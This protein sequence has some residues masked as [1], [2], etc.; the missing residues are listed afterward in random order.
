MTD[1]IAE[2]E[3]SLRRRRRSDETIRQY[4]NALRR[5]ERGLPAG[6]VRCTPDELA[7][8]IYNGRRSE[9][10]HTY[11]SSVVRGFGKWLTDPK[12]PWLDWHASEDLPEAVPDT[13]FIRPAT[14]AEFAEIR[15]R[16]VAPWIDL[17]ELAGWGGLRCIEI[18]RLDRKH[19]TREEIRILGKGGKWRTVPTHPDIWTRFADRP[20]GP[21]ARDRDGTPL[22][23]AQVIARGDY[24]LRK[25][26]VGVTMHQLR[27]RFATRVYKESDH[28]IRLV[29]LLLGHANVNTTQRYLGVDAE[30]ATD[31]VTRLTVAA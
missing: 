29:Q 11:Y 2:Y 12:D 22:N 20:A 14:E 1:L 23:R 8:W 3:A 31:V 4:I 28:N 19:L 10:T 24:Q 30:E 26:G 9:T 13:A 16:A 15:A 21:I 25:L 17:Y 6:V 5:M 27:K 7:D 18:H